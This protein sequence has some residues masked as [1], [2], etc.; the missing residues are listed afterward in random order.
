MQRNDGVE[1][2]TTSWT[3]LNAVKRPDHPTHE[4]A[5][6]RFAAAYWRPVFC[7]IRKV[8]H[9]LQDAEDLTQAFFFYL[10]D[11]RKIGDADRDRGRFRTY[12]LT[13]LKRFLSDHGKQR[14]KKQVVFEQ[15]IIPISSLIDENDRQFVPRDDERP[16]DIF[17]KHGRVPW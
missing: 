15:E 12:L 10:W 7:F 16:E 3:I 13:L 9:P 8:G 5:M 6:N 2:P 14:E 17:M 4:V 1:F 11:R